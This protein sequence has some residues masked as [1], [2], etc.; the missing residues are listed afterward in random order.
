[1]LC[2][3]PD[4]SVT[5]DLISAASMSYLPT[6]P[7]QKNWLYISG[8]LLLLFFISCH[9]WDTVVVGLFSIYNSE[10]YGYARSLIYFFVFNM[11]L[12]NCKG[13]SFLLFLVRFVGGPSSSPEKIWGSLSFGVISYLHS[14]TPLSLLFPWRWIPR[15]L[16]DMG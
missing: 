14:P 2:D 10:G 13:G 3:A 12:K 8:F 6:P 15:C 1:M 9:G 4:D 7:N 5:C 16:Y 11:F